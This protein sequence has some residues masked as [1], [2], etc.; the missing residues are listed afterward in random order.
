MLFRF[1]LLL[2]TLLFLSCSQPKHFSS[3]Y[4]L[5]LKVD[6]SEK[7]EKYGYADSKG[8]IVIPFGKYPRV[9]TDTIK[10]IGFVAVRH[11]GLSQVKGYYAIDRNDEILFQVY[12][13]DNGVDIVE[14]GLFRI[15]DEQGLIGFANMDGEIVI[16]PR[17]A[18]VDRFMDGLA[19][20]CAGCPRRTYIN[21]KEETARKKG[22]EYQWE[23]NEI[24][25]NRKH[26]YG[27]I[28]RSGD[29]VLQAVYDRA[30]PFVDG[31]AVVFK[32]GSAYCIDKK[33]NKV[34]PDFQK[35]PS[36]N[37]NWI[38]AYDRV[39]YID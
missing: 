31:I 32:D 18:Y 26:A 30:G 33:G 11:Q 1:L 16:Q 4:Y 34:T 22:D 20:F 13:F 15:V 27:Y 12:P 17:Y 37:P 8:K 39:K 6:T 5:Y 2:G 28:N 19:S 25:I 9:F 35:H 24:I 3:E 14:E 23:G 21:D 38:R 36:F 7:S 29:T 10:T